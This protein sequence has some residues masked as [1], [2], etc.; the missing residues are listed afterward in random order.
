MKT[1]TYIT[2][3]TL[4]IV[5]TACKPKQKMSA[6]NTDNNITFTEII[7]GTHSNFKEAN[8][9]IVNSE[10]ELRKVYATINMTRRPGFYLPKIDFSKESII[11]LFLGTKTTGGYSVKINNINLNGKK[12]EIFYK[13]TTP[14]G[15]TTTIITQPFYIAKTKKI[16]TA[17]FVKI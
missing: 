8:S 10:D 4:L 3:L 14:N 1:I 12:A 9:F 17:E 7:S 16:N 15:I 2:L 13:A 6:K 5:N 11:C